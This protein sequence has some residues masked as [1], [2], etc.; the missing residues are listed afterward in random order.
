A[1]RVVVVDVRV[2]QGC[3]RCSCLAVDRRVAMP[4]RA[5]DGTV[6]NR[7]S[8]GSGSTATI[9]F[10]EF[11]LR[12]PACRGQATKHEKWCWVLQDGLQAT[13]EGAHEGA[14]LGSSSVYY[15]TSSEK[16]RARSY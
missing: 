2:H 8:A 3:T 11:A 13:Q 15:A 6:R 12:A 14:I 10:H 1:A 9:G 16:E 5:N 7:R 4:A